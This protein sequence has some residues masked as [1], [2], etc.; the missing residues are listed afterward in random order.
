MADIMKYIGPNHIGPEACCAQANLSLGVLRGGVRIDLKVRIKAEAS[1]PIGKAIW[2]D[3]A[4]PLDFG[5][6]RNWFSLR[7]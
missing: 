5:L 1:I 6:R 4:L 7:H 2:E 3:V